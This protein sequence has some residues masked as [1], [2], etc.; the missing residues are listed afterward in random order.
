MANS[1]VAYLPQPQTA[2][3]API[4]TQS[5]AQAPTPQ[6]DL[7]RKRLM[8]EAWRAYRGKFTPPL[9]KAKPDDTD[10]N[11]LNNRC[12][13]IV[14]KGVSFLFGPVLKIEATGEQHSTDASVAQAQ[15]GPIQ[16]FI[17]GFWGDDDTCMTRL[18]KLAMNGAVCG[19]AFV[20]LM[21]APKG[22]KYPRIVILDPQIVRKVTD[23][24][25]C[26]TV[27]AYIIEYPGANDI[28][29]R[30][31]IA[32]IDP[33]GQANAWGGYDPQDTW[34]ITNYTRRGPSGA[35]LQVGDAQ[36]W[37]YPFAPILSCQ[38]LPNPN[39]SWGTPDL[40]ADLI[41][42]NK[43]L[44][45]IQSNTSRIIKFHA[46]PK[47]WGKG[48][49]AS[50]LRVGIN[51][52]FIIEAPDGT[53]A[54]LEMHSDL[55]SSLKFA[56]NLRGDMDEQSRV[57]AVA[58]GRLEALPRGT[59]SG[60]A[61]Q[62]LFQ[63]LT[64]KTTQKRRTYGEL[65]RDVTR[66]ALVMAGLI[67]ATQFE[68]Y[69]IDLHWSDLLPADDL[70]T[71]QTALLWQ[72]M[73]VSEDTLMQRGGFSPDD[74]ARKTAQESQKK[75]VLATKGQA[76]PPAQAQQGQNAQQQPPAQTAPSD[77]TMGGQAA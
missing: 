66:A 18:S 51:D 61:L 52:V 69:K 68:D 2:D 65:V 76:I 6:E 58:L 60:V 11:V 71:A 9:K 16:S 75:L 1:M 4:T 32:R 49:S 59:I 33:D 72:Q 43:V 13:P 22:K 47:T 67:A 64:E 24:D 21:P 30:Q 27:W 36:D 77:G 40:T 34:T 53:L 45:F 7:E 62:L 3:D 38:N 15:T 10:D 25:D 37:P 41:E 48:F 39:E 74:E 57:P 56:E 46:H 17:T 5:L 50:Q 23:P 29:K 35:W 12:E 19:E 31:I 28:Q 54:N 20:K 63:P 73:G 14:N 42:M 8:H 55:A 70:Q 26:E 44:N